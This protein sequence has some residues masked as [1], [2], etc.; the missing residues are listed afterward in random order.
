MSY[1]SGNRIREVTQIDEPIFAAGP[2][3]PNGASPVNGIC[4]GP[5]TITLSGPAETHPTGT[6]GASEITLIAKVT[7]G[8]NPSSGVVVSLSVDVTP[9][10]FELRWSAKSDPKPQGSSQ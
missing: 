9:A 6:G 2:V 4:V 7:N 1:R 8:A 10:Q 3:C 5:I